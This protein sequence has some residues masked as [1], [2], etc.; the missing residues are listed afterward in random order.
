MM[1]GLKQEDDQDIYDDGT[2]ITNKS[3]VGRIKSMFE[4][5]VQG[6]KPS[7]PSKPRVKPSP[8]KRN[9]SSH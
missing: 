3:S 5:A 1:K 9:D 4:P 7:V 8:P 6:P 2:S